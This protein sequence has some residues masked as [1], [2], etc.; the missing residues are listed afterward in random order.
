M[1]YKNNNNIHELIVGISRNAAVQILI[2]GTIVV[3][4]STKITF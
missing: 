3:E 1:N 4:G 2:F